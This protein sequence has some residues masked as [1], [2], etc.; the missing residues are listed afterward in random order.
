M[1]LSFNDYAKKLEALGENVP[2]IFKAV[3]GRG[4]KHFV[5][6]AVRETDRAGAVD[7]GAYKRNWNAEVVEFGS[8]EYGIAC[9][10][11]MEYASFL[12]DGYE[13]HRSHFVPFDK[14]QG[15]P[16]TQKLISSFKAKYPNAKGFIAKP[17]RF[18]GLKIG[19]I[20]MSD[21][22]GWAIIEL[23]S[24]LDAAMFAKKHNISKSE[25]KKYLK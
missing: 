23:Q 22:E 18:K 21:L 12:E 7:T 3:A 25:A 14:M 9:M 6:E 2:K 16:K 13:I 10:N 17:R 15:S 8:G 11:S 20:A 19:R 24:E 4:A 1:T 5:G